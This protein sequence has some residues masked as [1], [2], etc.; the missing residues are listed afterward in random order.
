MKRAANRGDLFTI[1]DFGILN[2]AALTFDRTF[3][4]VGLVRFGASNP[5]G[6]SETGTK[7]TV[8]G[9]GWIEYTKT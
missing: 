3:V 9:L 4:V 8:H 2:F 5:H 6:P 7:R 1:Y